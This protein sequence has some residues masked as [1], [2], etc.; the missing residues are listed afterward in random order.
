MAIWSPCSPQKRRSLKLPNNTSESCG[1]KTQV[2]LQTSYSKNP[3]KRTTI[4]YVRLKWFLY[5]HSRPLSS[6]AF[7][8]VFFKWFVY[9]RNNCYL[10]AS[11][12]DKMHACWVPTCD[13]RLSSTILVNIV[14]RNLYTPEPKLNWFF[15]IFL[16]SFIHRQIRQL[17]RL[18]NKFN[19][20]K[21]VSRASIFY[22]KKMKFIDSKYFD[23]FER[24]LFITK[25]FLI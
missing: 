21:H 22:C 19:L 16:I 5:S 17:R 20:Y 15:L 3:H 4:F 23:V 24:I 13:N 7:F 18:F 8:R 1:L 10:K 12:F 14:Q 6:Y 9:C 11:E 2:K 25:W